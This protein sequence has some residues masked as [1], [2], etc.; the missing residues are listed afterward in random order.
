M[1]KTLIS[2]LKLKSSI[3][4]WRN[5]L[6][7]VGEDAVKLLFDECDITPQQRAAIIAQQLGEDI[8]AEEKHIERPW[9]YGEWSNNPAKRYVSKLSYCSNRYTKI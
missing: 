6:G 5:A 8:D 2:S 9:M 1:D 7:R 4:N 3:Y